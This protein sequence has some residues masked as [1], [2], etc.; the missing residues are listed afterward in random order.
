[1]TDTKSFSC[2]MFRTRIQ[3]LLLFRLDI[4]SILYCIYS[5]FTKNEDIH[6]QFMS[7]LFSLIL[8]LHWLF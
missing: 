8:I 7:G 6:T 4:R 3:Q 1:M 2:Y 5:C